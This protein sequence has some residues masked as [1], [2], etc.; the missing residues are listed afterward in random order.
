MRILLLAL[1]ACAASGADFEILIRN[2]R[3]IDGT[4]NPWYRADVGVRDGKIAAVGNL[5]R[6]SA[7]RVIDAMER[8]VA[9]GFIDV[10]THIEG[11]ID[12][13]TGADNYVT[14]GVTTVVTG[15]CGGSVA[16]LA[17]WFASLEKLG[18]GIN[19]A[20]LAGHNTVRRAVMGT[21]NRFAT[22]EEITKMQG[23]VEKMMGDGAVGFST[24]LI[25]IPGTY[26]NPDEVVAL[27]KAAGKLGGVYSSHMRDEG[28]KVLDAI[29]EA[30]RVG[31]EAGMRVQLS[32]FK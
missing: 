3:V 7:G 9:P 30:L 20:S 32:H 4:G 28:E 21:A 17:E 26:S 19:V 13:V 18:I 24:G 31:R 16:N 25:Y 15:N 2:A 8:V 22:P 5:A 14:D 11:G 23:V 12:K 27:A 10:H 29:E 6:A 1:L